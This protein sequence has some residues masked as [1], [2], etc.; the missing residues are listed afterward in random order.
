M[1]S[2]DVRTEDTP[3]QRAR[4]IAESGRVTC[5]GGRLRY[6]LR[7]RSWDVAVSDI[8]VVGEFTTSAGPLV[9]DY[10]VVFVTSDGRDRVASYYAA[11]WKTAW[12]NLEHEIRHDLDLWLT[13]STSWNSR[14]LWPPELKDR[15]LY[16]LRRPEPRTPI[17]RFLRWLFLLERKA[18]LTEDVRRFATSPRSPDPAAA[19]RRG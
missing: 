15:P 16:V 18:Q 10:F 8:R 6:D 5:E 9:D 2:D 4:R 1:I 19:T 11:D 12:P 14:V 3:E 17:Q 7:A 13:T